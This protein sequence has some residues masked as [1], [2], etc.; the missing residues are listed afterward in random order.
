VN[1]ITHN[2]LGVR[3]H[4]STLLRGRGVDLG[5]GIGN[6]GIGIVITEASTRLCIAQLETF[7][8]RI[9]QRSSTHFRLTYIC[10]ASY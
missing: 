1:C 2:L 8:K 9:D 3:L 7:N 5:S 4:L 10:W 6:Q